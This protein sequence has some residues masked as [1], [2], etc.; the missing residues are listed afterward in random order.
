MKRY[1]ELKNRL[2]GLC[3]DH[4]EI[5]A[6]IVIGSQAR[7]VYGADEY[8]DLDLIIACTEPK[9]LLYDDALINKLG[10]PIYSFVE[11][12]IAGEKERRILFEGSLDVDMIIMSEDNLKKHLSS[13]SLDGIM[14]RGFKLKCD[15]C[16]V[17]TYVNNIPKISDESYC[18]LSEYNFRNLVN[19]FMFHTVWA[20]KKIRRGEL[21]TAIM[22]INCYL[23]SK[24]LTVIEM[25]EH[26][27]HGMKY[28]TWHN[29]RMAEQ[30]TEEFIRDKLRNCFARYNAE[31]M[32][33]ALEN[34]KQLFLLLSRE[35]AA[36]Y[37]Y[38]TG[39]DE[40]DI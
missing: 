15:K 8:S 12:T 36:A 4:T 16:D 18:P 13:H 7:E 19:D 37:N 1:E 6:V 22:C 9:K 17:S 2:L 39:I 27:I 14:N 34:T 26:N 35:C 3:E 40:I 25:Y 23:K 38:T 10:K 11:D 32:L 28:D 30:W 20:E 29:G 5:K 21:W 24:L 31:E 33:S